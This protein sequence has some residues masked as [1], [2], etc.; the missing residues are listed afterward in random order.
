MNEQIE[1]GEKYVKINDKFFYMS[2]ENVE[3]IQWWYERF[4]HIKGIQFMEKLVKLFI[5]AK[6]EDYNDQWYVLDILKKHEKEISPLIDL[7]YSNYER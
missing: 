2:T 1:F 7:I 6:P 3:F 5:I 4:G